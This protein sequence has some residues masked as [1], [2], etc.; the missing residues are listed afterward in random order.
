MAHA[1]AEGWTQANLPLDNPHPNQEEADS[2]TPNGWPNPVHRGVQQREYPET[3]VVILLATT[4][5]HP[6]AFLTENRNWTICAGQRTSWAQL[7][8]KVTKTN[9]RHFIVGFGFLS[10]KGLETGFHSL[11]RWT[12]N[13]WGFSCLTQLPFLP[14][15]GIIGCT[16]TP[17]QK[18]KKI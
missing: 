9:Q 18:N 16:A 8:G 12:S 5:P 2:P 3:T 4:S 13:S 15:T 17:R 6:S 14:G 11:P 1:S 10:V 7:D